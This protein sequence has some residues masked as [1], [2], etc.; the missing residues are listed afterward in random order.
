MIETRPQKTASK[1]YT[2]GLSVWAMAII[3]TGTYLR[4]RSAEDV[5]GFDW[6][7]AIQ[8]AVYMLAGL[9]GLALLLGNARFGLQTVAL[10][11]FI[12]T[13]LFS[14]WFSQYQQLVAGYLILFVGIT[15]LT[16]GLVKRARSLRDL[17]TIENIWF[18]IILLSLLKD[19]IISLL[20]PGMQQAYGVRGSARLGMGVTNAN[21]LGFSSAL[22]FWLTFQDDISRKRF[23]LF[24]VPRVLLIAAILLTRSR[25]AFFCLMVGGILRL[26]LLYSVRPFKPMHL[27]FVFIS[28]LVTLFTVAALAW[29][30]E[31]SPLKSTLDVFNR[32]DQGDS[33]KNLTG[34][35]EIWHKAM[36]EINRSSTSFVI[37]YGYGVSRFILNSTRPQIPFF[38]ANAHN[39]FLEVLINCGLFG[40]IAYV[41]ILLLAFS[42]LYRFKKLSAA[43]TASFAARAAIVVALFFLTSLTESHFSGKISPE[44]VLFLF[45]FLTLEQEKYFKINNSSLLTGKERQCRSEN[46][47][48]C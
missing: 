48:T 2:I 23:F 37:G 31:F 5:P 28:L 45:Y 32:A 11:I 24:L 9:I 36:E 3:L 25:M 16:L 7:V 12:G 22:L 14:A 44:S 19:S 13:C 40:E 15:I 17:A 42:W 29:S 21:A 46:L 20:F 1:L 30:F 4:N 35:T 39:T 34:R 33:I 10:S 41:A 26:Y 47:A 38:A 43:F 18:T 6:L 27:R 8:L